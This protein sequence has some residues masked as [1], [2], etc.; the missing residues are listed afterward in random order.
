MPMGFGAQSY[1]YQLPLFAG[2]LLVS[3][4]VLRAFRR[5]IFAESDSKMFFIFSL[6]FLPV[7]VFLSRFL[8]F[9]IWNRLH[10]YNTLLSY[11]LF[12][13]IVT[14]LSAGVG[15]SAVGVRTIIAKIKTH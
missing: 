4:F 10:Y 2:G 3:Y 11:I 14:G 5:A 6:I 12:M 1:W 13:T 7:I 8:N 9:S 15:L